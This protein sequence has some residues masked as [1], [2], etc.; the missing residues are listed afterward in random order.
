MAIAWAEELGHHGAI[1]DN[2]VGASTV[3]VAINVVVVSGAGTKEEVSAA[4]VD[5]RMTMT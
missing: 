5:A 4:E 1:V 3:V 2:E